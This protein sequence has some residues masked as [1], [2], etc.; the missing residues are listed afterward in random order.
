M[1]P[2][3]TSRVG[4]RPAPHIPRH[5]DRRRHPDRV[6]ERR[7]H[8]T[9]ACSGDCVS[10]PH[11][12]HFGDRVPET[13]ACLSAPNRACIEWCLP[14]TWRRK[15]RLRRTGAGCDPAGPWHAVTGTCRSGPAAADQRHDLPGGTGVQAAGSVQLPAS[16]P[17]AMS[18]GNM[19]RR[20]TTPGATTTLPCFLRGR[21][22]KLPLSCGLPTCYQFAIN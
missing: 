17:G 20:K 7:Q 8:R 6:A 3:A 9:P 16:S 22:N 2:I 12:N 1:E 18:D 4:G 15:D 21:A 14:K 19:T 5:P 10:L 11:C 13:R